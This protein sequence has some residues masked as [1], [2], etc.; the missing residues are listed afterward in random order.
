VRFITIL[1]VC[2][3]LW[4]QTFQIVPSTAP[5]GGTGS[6]LVTFVSP[7]GNEPIS[8][9]WKVNLGTEV[10]AVVGDLVAGDSAKAAQKTLVC[11]PATKPKQEDLVFNCILAGAKKPIPNG[12]IL[13]VKYAIKQQAAPHASVVR[14]LDGIAVS[15]QGGRVQDTHLAQSEGTITIR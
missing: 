13:L 5:R 2:S 15:D 14:I 1:V 12:T 11:A 8:L 9:Q 4:A 6:L 10:T 3:S 7:A